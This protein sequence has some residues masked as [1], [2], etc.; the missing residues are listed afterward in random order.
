MQGSSQ[1]SSTGA[2]VMVALDLGAES[3]RR[4]KY[5]ASMADRLSA[6]LIGIGAREPILPFPDDNMPVDSHL[7]ELGQAQV[8]ADLVRTESVF[9]QAAGQRSDIEW[10]SQTGTPLT[11]AAEQARAADFLIV[12]R[13]GSQDSFD[14]LMGIDPADLVFA[15]GRPILVIPPGK[16]YFFSRHVL[17]AWKDT[18]ESRRAV[19]D[20]LPLLKCAEEVEVL[21]VDDAEAGVN[22]VCS[23]LLRHGIESTPLFRNSGSRSAAEEI[24]R[25]AGGE[26]S[27]LI[28]SGAYGHARMREWIFGG[29]TWELLRESSVPC[30]M[31]H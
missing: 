20:S 1:S 26:G 13:R 22:D 8:A 11:F 31:S 5:A 3:E 16:D 2:A 6:A 15:V 21:T 27:D 18:R 10:R 30:L 24:L 23:F 14:T 29:V 9:R 25:I 28:V 19:M 4:V 7:L 17:V 12:S